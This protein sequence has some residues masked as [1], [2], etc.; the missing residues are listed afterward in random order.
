MGCSSGSIENAHLIV[1]STCGHWSRAGP[2]PG[3]PTS[4]DRAS[5]LSNLEAVT[6]GIRSGGSRPGASSI[7]LICGA[8]VFT[9]RSGATTSGSSPNALFQE[10]QELRGCPLRSGERSGAHRPCGRLSPS[11]VGPHHP[12]ASHP[13]R[14]TPIPS[15][16]KRASL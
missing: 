12:E 10:R 5:K 14:V 7:T 11:M 8:D 15:G 3:G 13:S 9:N 2:P 1:V 16:I 6:A 4:K